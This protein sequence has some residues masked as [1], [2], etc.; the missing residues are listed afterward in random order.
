VKDTIVYVTLIVA[1]ATWVTAHVTIAAGL[2]MR[3]PRW[4]ALASVALPPLA[5]WWAYH[6]RM[7][8]RAIAWVAALI[9]YAVARFLSG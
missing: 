2:A 9:V 7:R 5:P 6:E 8:V 3:P 1:F 4:R